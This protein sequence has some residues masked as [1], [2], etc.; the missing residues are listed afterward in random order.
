VRQA[1]ARSVF[2]TRDAGA[3]ADLRRLL[4]DPQPAVRREAAAA[5]G[6]LDVSEAVAA[7]LGA[8]AAPDVDRTLE[9][10]L[11]YALIEINEPAA[12]VLGLAR[13]EPPVQRGA[14]LA[15]DQMAN[16]LL[17]PEQVLPLLEAGHAPLRAAALMVVTGR[18]AW[19]AAVATELARRLDGRP[20]S[21]EQLAVTR[22]LLIRFGRDTGVQ[23]LVGRVLARPDLAPDVPRLVLTALADTAG[24]Q[25]HPTWVGPLT[26][27]L[28]SPDADRASAA[29][30]VVR[31]ARA[32]GFDEV[33]QALGGDTSRDPL[34]RI[35]AL[36]A[37]RGPV[38]EAGTRGRGGSGAP[39]MDAAGF[40]LAL[41]LLGGASVPVRVQAA[42]LL[43]RASLT[44]SQMLALAER[45]DTAGPMELQALTPA[46]GR[47]RDPRVGL[48]LLD[49][50]GKSPG[51]LGLT[52]G[53]IRRSFR[54]YPPEVV[55][56]SGRLVQQ[57]LDRDRD[58]QARLTALA[59]VLDEGDVTRGRQL[60]AAGQGNCLL[61]HRAGG[62]GGPVGPDLSSIGRIRSGSELLQA[63]VY[64]SDYL[65]R[66]YET[67]GIG[68]ADGRTYLGTVQRETTETVELT[69]AA[70]PPVRLARDQ[71]RTRTP[72]PTSL[73]PPGLETL[74]TRQEL[75]DLIAYLSSLK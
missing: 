54:N 46:L 45:I 58:K 43:A 51:L 53:D 34:L 11:T 49:A 33:L 64:P 28:R 50:L 56:A 74:F 42:D 75:G 39:A 32:S 52:E 4:A 60:F 41:N 22:E 62:I 9:H 27:A 5:L 10:A 8:L 48:A 67:Y 23:D 63:I 66:G 15:L 18:S 71:I 31:A 3:A 21:A 72:S 29:V 30:R 1:G 59:G 2:T 7:I 36:Q 44:T 55:T 57:L 19:S 47:S 68:M 6:R 20:Q 65:A 40:D 14:L 13:P 12:T 24:V 61:C 26:A 35:A 37:I 69:P 16:S 38:V 70:G 17:R 25:V 73:M